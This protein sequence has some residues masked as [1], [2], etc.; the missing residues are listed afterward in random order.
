VI[1]A[2]ALSDEVVWYE[3]T[4]GAGGFGSEQVISAAV[5]GPRAIFVADVDRDGDPDV[6]SASRND[7]KI[8]WHE[9]RGGQFS[10]AAGDSAPAVLL[11]GDSSDL[12]EIV[13]THRG[14]AG[15]GDEELATLG[16]LFEE[17]PGDPLSSAEAN[18]LIDSVAVYRDTGSGVFEA[19]SDTLV[20]SLGTL[21]LAAGTQTITLPD[22]HTA[23]QVVFGVP[24]TFFVVVTLTSDANSQ[25]P[26]WFRVTH[27][28]ES[29]STAEDASFDIPLLMEFAAEVSSRIVLAASPNSDE[30]GDRLYDVVETDTGVFVSTMDTGSDPFDADTDGDGFDDGWEVALGSDPNDPLETSPPWVPALGS[31]GQPLLFLML[32]GSA[33][34]GLMHGRRRS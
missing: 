28:P 34:R 3:N 26:H 32:A 10:L 14:R 2:A 25:T 24:G 17:A 4:D 16:L 18:A 23:A 1:A 6:V 12:L 21:S 22:D 27:V 7:D 33:A 29:G 11:Q 19:G 30:D 20:S 9:N 8:A 31:W 5:D 13:M 15:D